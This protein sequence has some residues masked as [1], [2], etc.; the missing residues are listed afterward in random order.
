MKVSK[1]IF[2]NESDTKFIKVSSLRVSCDG[3][4]NSSS[5]GHPL[6]WLQINEEKGFV[7]CPYCETKFIFEDK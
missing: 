1:D 6:V 2:M 7:S 4:T 5:E 3:E